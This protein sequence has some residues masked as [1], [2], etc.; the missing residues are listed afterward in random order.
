MKK[1]NS[2]IEIESSRKAIDRENQPSRVL[3][4]LYLVRE[5]ILKDLNDSKLDKIAKSKL[6]NNLQEVEKDIRREE[7]KRVQPAPA[8]KPAAPAAHAEPAQPLNP[9]KAEKVKKDKI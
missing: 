6:I 1:Q 8:A 4:D 9:G 3:P 7:L 5:S 2:N